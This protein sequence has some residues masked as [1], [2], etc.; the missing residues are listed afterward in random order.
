M[1]CGSD[2]GRRKA[3]LST[4]RG[5]KPKTIHNDVVVIKQMVNFAR[6]RRM[7]SED[8]LADLTL[9]RPKRTPQ[10]FWT[11]EQVELILQN[12][13]PRYRPLLQFLADT[14]VRIGEARWLTWDD[15]DFEHGVA[16]IRAKEGWR[17]KSGDERVIPLSAELCRVLRGLPRSSQWVFTAWSSSRCAASD[18]QVS[19]RLALTHLKKVLRKLGLQGHLHTFR[20]SFISHALTRGVPEAIVRDW[21]GHVD[22][23]VIRVYTHIADQVSRNAMDG[24]FPAPQENPAGREERGAINNPKRAQNVRREED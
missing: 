6:R 7:I 4:G 23:E 17:P 3:P 24:L 16:R 8:P 1:R 5:A 9:S 20:H 10:P 13:A 2:A 18:R 22:R 19:D 11:R 14:G 15:V 12:A 21:V